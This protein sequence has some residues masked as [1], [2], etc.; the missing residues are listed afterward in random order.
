MKRLT[1]GIERLL[2]CGL[3]EALVLKATGEK[4]KKKKKTEVFNENMDK[5]LKKQI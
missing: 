1:V 4:L 3:V 2:F 5:T